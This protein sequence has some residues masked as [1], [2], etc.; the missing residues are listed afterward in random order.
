MPVSLSAVSSVWLSRVRLGSRVKE[1]EFGASASPFF[2]PGITSI[3]SAL[4]WKAEG[5]ELD[6]LCFSA[7]PAG[8]QMAQGAMNYKGPL[9]PLD[10]LMQPGLCGEQPVRQGSWRSFAPCLPARD[11]EGGES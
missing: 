10:Q 9:S 5:S 11:C 2:G 1:A 3:T 4:H 6:P 7:T 8:E